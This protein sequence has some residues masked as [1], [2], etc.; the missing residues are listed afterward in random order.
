MSRM[1]SHIQI[2]TATNIQ[3]AFWHLIFSSLSPGAA[4]ACGF[5]VSLS[6]KTIPSSYFSWHPNSNMCVN[7]FNCVL[8]CRLR[9]PWNT[10]LRQKA[11]PCLPHSRWKMCENSKVGALSELVFFL[12][13][14]LAFKNASDSLI[15]LHFY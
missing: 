8:A 10:A 3:A 6:A 15:F 13:H 7:V 4:Y 11:S 1:H 2:K 12:L 9:S 14:A 5:R